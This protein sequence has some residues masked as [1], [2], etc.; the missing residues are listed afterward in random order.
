[1]LV[2]AAPLVGAFLVAAS[3]VEDYRHDKYDVTA[4]SLLGM[5]IA[6]LIYRRYYPSL[7]SSSCDTPY[8]NRAES[9]DFSRVRDEEE[10]MESIDDFEIGA[11]EDETNSHDSHP[12]T[13]IPR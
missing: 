7:W 9:S 10:A 2:T 13:S 5:L 3:R 11:M 1:M 8:A 12:L 4:G 6:F